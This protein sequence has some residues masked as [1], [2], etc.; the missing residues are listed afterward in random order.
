MPET[1]CSSPILPELNDLTSRLRVPGELGRV[2]DHQ[3]QPVAL[4]P[5][6][7]IPGVGRGKC[8]R[9]LNEHVHAHVQCVAGNLVVVGVLDRY[10]D[11]VDPPRQA[12]PGGRRRCY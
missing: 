8:H 6:N 5:L 3:V 11:A 10:D 7:E 9:L 4:R 2:A 1:S 12:G